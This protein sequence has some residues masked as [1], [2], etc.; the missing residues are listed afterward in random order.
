MY[1]D[2]IITF[3]TLPCRVKFICCQKSACEVLFNAR[4]QGPAQ[5]VL[6]WEARNGPGGTGVKF[7]SRHGTRGVKTI[8][9]I[10]IYTYVLCRLI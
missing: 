5:E 9:Y 6:N 2:N 1:I 3:V 4:L 10:Y 8:K 7:S